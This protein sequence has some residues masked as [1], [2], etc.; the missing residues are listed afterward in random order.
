MANFKLYSPEDLR[1]KE[2]YLKRKA[3]KPVHPLKGRKVTWGDK[4]S[5]ALI[6]KKHKPLVFLERILSYD[7]TP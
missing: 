1:R 4:I 7:T 5:K 2:E 6:G 3:L